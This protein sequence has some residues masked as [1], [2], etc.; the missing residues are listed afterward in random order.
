MSTPLYQNP[1]LL[2]GL[3]LAVLFVFLLY[4]FG[5]TLGALWEPFAKFQ[6]DPT[7]PLTLTPMFWQ[8]F[9]SLTFSG[10]ISAVTGVLFWAL[11][12]Q[13]VLPVTRRE[14]GQALSHFF[15][16]SL[17]RPGH[18][19]FVE[20]G[21]LVASAAEKEHRALA[22]GVILVDSVSGIVLQTDTHFTRAHG[23]G[24]VFTRPDEYA[25]EQN[26]LD[27]RQQTRTLPKVVAL[28]RDGI[29]VR[30]DLSVNFALHSGEPQPFREWD[31]ESQAPFAFDAKHAPAAVYGSPV[32]GQ[33]P[34]D[35]RDLPVLLAADVWR[36]LLIQRDLES[37]FNPTNDGTNVLETL[38]TH[39]YHRLT[40]ERGAWRSS[41][42]RV[43]ADRRVRV[44]SV[45]LSNLSLP[46]EV[47]EKRL[48]NWKEDWRKRAS[49]FATEKD[50]DLK[51]LRGEGERQARKRAVE[52]LTAFVRDQLVKKHRPLPSEVTLRLTEATYQLALDLHVRNQLS[53]DAMQALTRM[54]G[55]AR[56]LHNG[57][58]PGEHE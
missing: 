41:E 3:A 37:L 11:I 52:E 43:L 28:T 54:V 26:V 17:G 38:Q 15:Q 2:G 29:E 22:S 32:R 31:N 27:L 45:T 10:F 34:P 19:I 46:A 40:G 9:I 53:N 56:N 25:T 13:F 50:P 48:N 1:R 5:D 57:Q 23:P 12:S 35:W 42:Y 47:R 39:I 14:R 33:T 36:E 6:A 24:V 49:D 18:A 20:N 16:H 4:L 44:L 21:K 58:A 7:Q 30:A 55:W 51:K 8:A